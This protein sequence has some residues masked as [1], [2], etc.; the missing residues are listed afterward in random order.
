MARISKP[1]LEIEYLFKKY[2]GDDLTFPTIFRAYFRNE[3]RKFIPYGWVASNGSVL[4][5][6]S[7]EEI[8]NV[9]LKDIFESN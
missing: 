8:A 1:Q 7:D 5:T 9:N 6:F 2:T 3:D 4:L